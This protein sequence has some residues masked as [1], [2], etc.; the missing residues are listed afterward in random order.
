MDLDVK[1]FGIMASVGHGHAALIQPLFKVGKQPR[2]DY[3]QISALICSSVTEK[4]TEENCFVP[5]VCASRR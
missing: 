3:F 1:Q 2:W 5:L 4:T